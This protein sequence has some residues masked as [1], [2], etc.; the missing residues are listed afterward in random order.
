LLCVASLP[1]E[2]Y[3]EHIALGQVHDF[4]ALFARR[5]RRADDV[6]Q[7]RQHMIFVKGHDT[8]RRHY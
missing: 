8:L 6:D 1:A 5:L 3:F 2:T 4:F 7:M